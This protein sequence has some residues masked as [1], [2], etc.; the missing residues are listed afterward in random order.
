[1]LSD[2]RRTEQNPTID[3]IAQYFTKSSASSIGVL[4][5]PVNRK[6]IFFTL[7]LIITVDQGENYLL[8]MRLCY[9]RRLPEFPEFF[10]KKIEFDL[11]LLLLPL[12]DASSFFKLHKKIK[13]NETKL[14]KIKTFFF[15]F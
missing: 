4:R 5:V 12:S 1:M 10:Y 3:S 15:R 9:R 8:V 6:Y 14:N 7:L 11:N 13:R 2:L